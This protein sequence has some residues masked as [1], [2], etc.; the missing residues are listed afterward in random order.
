MA[1]RIL[2]YKRDYIIEMKNHI[3]TTSIEVPF[4]PNY[5]FNHVIALSKWWPEEYI[6]ESIEPDT[7]FVFKTGE[8]HYSKN[9]VVEF[10]PDKKFAWLTTESIRRADNFDWTGTRFI[11]ELTPKTEN[12]LIEF[13]Y[14]GIV[15]ENEVEKLAQICDMTIKEML[16]AWLNNR[17]ARH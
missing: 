15:L 11:F 10:E 16:A 13:T 4:S 14:D 6:G 12:T 2:F 7:E 17:T 1:S 5:V 8:G 9:R 3:Y